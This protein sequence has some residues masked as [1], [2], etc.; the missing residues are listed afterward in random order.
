MYCKIGNNVPVCRSVCMPVCTQGCVRGVCVEPDICHCDFSYVGAN[1]S[2]QCQCN[3]HADCAG[4]DKLD[5]C[6]ECHNNTMVRFLLLELF[7]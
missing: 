5:Q 2:I 4:P 6:L 1:C 3:N 7:T